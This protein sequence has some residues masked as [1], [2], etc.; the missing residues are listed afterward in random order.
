[1]DLPDWPTWAVAL[2]AAC[3]AAGYLTWI[4]LYLVNFPQAAVWIDRMLER[5]CEAVA[6]ARLFCRELFDRR[7]STP[8]G[9]SHGRRRDTVTEDS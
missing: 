6:R 9:E 7:S 8:L 4:L 3:M 2:L 1:M 5:L